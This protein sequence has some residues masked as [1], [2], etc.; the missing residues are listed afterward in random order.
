[1]LQGE[2]I[3]CSSKRK[4]VGMGCRGSIV[5]ASLSRLRA[6]H[7]A[8]IDALPLEDSC[9]PTVDEVHTLGPSTQIC[10]APA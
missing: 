4:Q 6:N 1:M 5:P 3:I 10:I 8:I 7:A 9:V 2:M